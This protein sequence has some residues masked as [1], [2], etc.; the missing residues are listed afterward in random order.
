MTT[1]TTTAP[2]RVEWQPHILNDLTDA[3]GNITGLDGVTH[4]V[5]HWQPNQ[6]PRLHDLTNSEA[7]ALVSAED[8]QAQHNPDTGDE[9]TVVTARAL[10]DWQTRHPYER[11]SPNGDTDTPGAP[12][13]TPPEANTDGT[14]P[15][16]SHTTTTPTP[17]GLPIAAPLPET[18]EDPPVTAEQPQEP[19][20]DITQERKRRGRPPKTQTAETAETTPEGAASGPDPDKGQL[21]DVPRVKVAIDDTDPTILKLAFSGSIEL[22]RGD[23]SD[24]QLLNR[25]KPGK[26]VSLQVEAHV[27]GD[28]TTHR[29]DS[30]GDVDAVVLTRS[31]IVHTLENV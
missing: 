8:A 5:I 18:P 7:A 11:T 10:T 17:S 21:F 26:P 23:P 28:K 14:T 12:P 25:L 24:M 30:D 27:A 16:V 29:R 31:L 3:T 22:N 9:Y 2:D 1:L 13:L 19:P 20:A 6:P 4:L 15:G